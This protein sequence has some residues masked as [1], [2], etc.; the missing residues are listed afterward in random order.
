MKKMQACKNA[1]DKVEKEVHEFNKP[2]FKEYNRI[3]G[4]NNDPQKKKEA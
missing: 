3:I 2:F 1:I 4:N